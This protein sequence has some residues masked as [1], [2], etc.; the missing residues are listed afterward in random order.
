MVE[1][2]NDSIKMQTIKRIHY[3]SLGE[4]NADLKMV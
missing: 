4:M 1:K 3:S 2:K